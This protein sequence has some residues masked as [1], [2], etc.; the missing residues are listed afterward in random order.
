M[1]SM[2]LFVMA[3][4]SPAESKENIVVSSFGPPSPCTT[5]TTECNRTYLFCIFDRF[6]IFYPAKRRLSAVV[7]AYGLRRVTLLSYLC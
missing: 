4:D 3:Q 5:V 2:A 7:P 6:S 1:L